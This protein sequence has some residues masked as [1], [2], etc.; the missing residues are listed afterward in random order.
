[1]I[2]ISGGPVAASRLPSGTTPMLPEDHG[3]IAWSVPIDYAAAS[4]LMSAIGAGVLHLTRIRRVPAA[5]ITN[6]HSHVAVAGATLTAGQCFAAL[7]T[8]A[9]TLLGVTAS[10]HTAWQSVGSKT[11]ALTAPV[12]VPAGDYYVG[13]WY[14]GTTAPTMI[15]SGSGTGGSNTVG[16]VSGSFNS[17]SADTGLTTTAPATL[18]AQT[19]AAIRYWVALS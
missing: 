19:A 7:Y 17:S 11:M 6:L 9:G 18:G 4:S 15:R 8:A 14:N 10:Q 5:T 2:T 12:A 1:M 3:L 13:L 16:Q